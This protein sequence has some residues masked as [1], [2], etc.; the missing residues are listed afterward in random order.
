[1]MLDGTTIV[2]TPAGDSIGYRI[3]SSRSIDGMVNV[4]TCI[5]TAVELHQYPNGLWQ[6]WIGKRCLGEGS[7]PNEAFERIPAGPLTPAGQR[8]DSCT[9]PAEP[10]RRRCSAC[11]RKA[12]LRAKEKRARA[13]RRKALLSG[14]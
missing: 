13:K 7:T 6:A 10:D 4:W 9:M 11:L 14:K 12:A 5:Y 2:R 3:D 8:C 1:M